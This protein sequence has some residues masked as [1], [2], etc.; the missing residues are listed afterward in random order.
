MRSN[1]GLFFFFPFSVSLCYL[2][3]PCAPAASFFSRLASVNKY[4]DRCRV[5][6]S[7]LRWWGYQ[8]R[9]SVFVLIGFLFASLAFLLL[10][11]H[12]TDT[13]FIVPIIFM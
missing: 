12:P 7:L 4:C 11:L 1:Q 10:F 13:R 3:G 2:G 9:F 5:F 8:V 6:A